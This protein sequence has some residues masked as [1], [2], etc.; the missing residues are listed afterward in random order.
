M[1]KKKSASVQPLLV[2]VD[3]S[4]HSR[5][6]LRWAAEMAQCIDAPVIVLHVVHDPESSPGYYMKVKKAKKL[7]RRFEDAAEEMMAEFV[8]DA[9]KTSPAVAE[10][11]DLETMTVIGL[12][13]TRILEVAKKRNARLIVVGSQG[14][15]GL[16]HFLLGSKALKVAQ[17]SSVPV[18]IVKGN[19]ARKKKSG[20]VK[21]GGAQ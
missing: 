8:A 9:R 1:T 4:P 15:T 14:R 11:K 5:E 13:V 20:E 6:A 18:T 7:L 19:E 12:P 2:A 17:L 21:K 10:L 3:F 16:P